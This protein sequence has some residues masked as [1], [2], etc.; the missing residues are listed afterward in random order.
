MTTL[1]QT[2]SARPRPAQSVSAIPAVASPM[3]MP[4]PLQ[5]Q[6]GGGGLSGADIWRVLRQ[7]MWWFLLAGLLSGLVGVGINEYLKRNHKYF[8]AR[9]KVLVQPPRQ[10]DPTGTVRLDEQGNDIDLKIMLQNQVQQLSNEPLLTELLMD[11][12][13]KTRQSKWLVQRA[14][15]GGSFDQAEAL[16]ALQWAFGARAVEGSSIIEVSL[17]AGDP[18]EAR[19]MLEE[20]VNRR[21]DQVRSFGQRGTGG[22][23]DVLMGLSRRKQQEISN[24]ESE[25]RNIEASL[26]DDA[27]E[28]TALYFRAMQLAETQQRAQEDL[29]LARSTLASVKE[30][31]ARGIEVAEVEARLAADPFI[32]ALR[33]NAESLSVRLEVARQA[34]GEKHQQFKS[35]QAE[36]DVLREQLASRE[37]DARA[38]LTMEVIA[39]LEGAVSG[40]EA[41][42]ATVDKQ[43]LDLN[44]TLTLISQTKSRIQSKRDELMAAREKVLDLEEKILILQTTTNTQQRREELDWAAKPVRP[45]TAAFPRLP[46][47]VGTTMAIGLGLVIGIAFLREVLDSSVKSPRDLA[48]VAQMNILGVVPHQDHDP[49]VGDAL[50]L[51]I[52]NS[53]HSMTAEQFRLIRSRLAHLAP[54][55]TTRTILIT[56]PQPGDGKTMVACNLAAGMALNGRKILLVDSNFRKPRIYSVFGISNE[57]GFSDCLRDPAQF[58]DMV[59]ETQIPNLFVLPAGPRPHSPTELIE[60]PA[61]TEVVDRALEDFDHVIFDSGPILFVSETGALAPQCDGVI[62]VVRA[63]HSTRGLL[64]RLRDQ[65]RS[66]NVEHLGVVLNAVRHHAGGYYGRNIRTYYAYTGNGNALP[67]INGQASDAG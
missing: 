15:R 67:A 8:M 57:R 10:Y 2:I 12:N 5:M 58:N 21:I 36:L 11:P 34:Y 52:A 51:A 66:F 59:V 3:V 30:A 50:D 32:S 24:L 38:R 16:E 62:S 56:S 63:R 31:V 27:G 28:G 47:T 18:E 41:R 25:L 6:H 53:P 23:A 60:G 20:I 54:L 26:S 61:F 1:P 46:V 55:E 29:L 19:L 13:S 17:K 64:G 35:L 40:A 44:T 43:L 4:V 42:M 33:T 14:T 37:D 48:R 9:G 22:Q 49:Q 65:L 39:S 45:T 7:N